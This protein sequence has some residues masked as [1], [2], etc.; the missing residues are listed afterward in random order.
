LRRKR[1]LKIKTDKK[2]GIIREF[3]TLLPY[4]KKYRMQYATGLAVLL[5]I[6]GAQIVIP[7]FVRG[8]VDVI[9]KGNY[10]LSDVAVYAI[11]AIIAGIVINV[12]R[13][14]WRFFIHGASRRIETEIR[15][16]IFAHLITLDYK[17]YQKNKIGDLMARSTHDL[18]A[19]RESIGF[20]LVALI[21]GT[22]MVIAI[23]TIIFIQ[24][25]KAAAWAII[26]LP[27]VMLCIVIFGSAV[28]RRFGRAQ[29][30]YSAMSEVVEETFAGINVVQSFVRENFFLK[31]FADTNNEYKAANMILAKIFGFFFPLTMFLSGL[32]TIIVL[33]IGGA[34]V[35]EGTLSP[36]N[37]TA[38]L[39]YFQMLI[40]PLM[41]AGFMVNMLQRGAVSLGRINDV[42]NQKSTIVELDNPIPI[43]RA[44]ADDN[45]P[46][47]EFKNL[48]FSY[49]TDDNGRNNRNVLNNVSFKI[50][51]GEWVGI[52][53]RIGA[54]KSTLIKTLVRLVDPPPG[55][56]F[57]RGVDVR[58]VALQD[59]RALFGV[60]LQDN[61]LFSDTIEEN[62]AYERVCRGS[63]PGAEEIQNAVAL[64]ALGRDL[65]I[66]GDGLKTVVGE[67]G[68]TLSGGQKQRTSIARAALSSPEILVLD[69]SLSAVDIE[70]EQRIIDE[71]KIVRKNKTTIIISLRPL[72]VRNVD[73]RVGLDVNGNLAEAG[74]PRAIANSG[75]YYSRILEIT[76]ESAAVNM[77]GGA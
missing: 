18:N 52:L 41:G 57:V 2:P 68:L 24:D 16:N 67:R 71:L 32:T 42:L 55:A 26:P 13:F 1:R 56:V 38:L 49:N 73:K 65:E 5:L 15:S 45:T 30:G 20:G 66:L 4:L 50:K 63:V 39:S 31:K 44:I 53:G 48:S 22:A 51:Q 34:Q 37:L 35:I 19:V 64:A 58:D 23:V 69:D 27:I 25:A 29:R 8:A 33:Y 75:G 74:E 54:G 10:K 6:D 62:I 7:Q 59:L 70:T 72:M 60:S 28:G 3:K 17:F 47:I 11:Y 43:P 76:N 40:W 61:Y 21:D 12:G 46:I 36:G 14:V 77:G 9:A